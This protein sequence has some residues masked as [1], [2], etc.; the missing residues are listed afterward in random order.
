MWYSILANGIVALHFAFV[1]FVL[2]G[3]LLILKWPRVIWLHLPAA[4]WGVLVECTGWICPL[5]PLEHWL[6]EQAGHHG[7][8]SDFVSQYALPLLY[9][10]GLTREV[11][12]GALVLIVNMVIYQWLWQR[13]RT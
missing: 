5:T 3:G 9:P 2:F 1:L 11:Q 6:R 13:S 4:V 10:E 8:D 12:L 7:Y